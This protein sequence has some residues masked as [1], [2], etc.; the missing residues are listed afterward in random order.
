MPPPRPAPG[1]PHD[2]LGRARAKLVLARQPLPP[3]GMWEDVCYWTQQAA[4]LAIKAVYQQ[5]G[6]RFPFLHDLGQLLD[7][8]EAQG[9]A[10]PTE[11]REA[12]K[13][14]VYAT[15]TRY[16]GLSTP[17]AQGHHTEALLISEA[18]VAWATSLVP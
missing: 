12:A 2:W 16:P 13:L 18:V 4:E 15:L 11:V 7:G 17:L 1:T 8:L 5:R 9:L 3:G 6:W 14:T 10:I